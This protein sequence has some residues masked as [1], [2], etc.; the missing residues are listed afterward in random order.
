MPEAR[1]DVSVRTRWQVNLIGSF[2]VVDLSDGRDCTPSSRKACGLLAYLVGRGSCAVPRERL[3]GLLW[4]RSGEEQARASLRQALH[5]IRVATS[6]E[7]P[8]VEGDRHHC[9]IVPQRVRG[10]GLH[11]AREEDAEWLPFEDLDGLSE[12]FDDWLA[13]ER[14][15]ITETV[16][17][18]TAT[19]V[20]RSL[21]HGMG[22]KLIPLIRR[23][24]RID[25]LNE[26]FVQ[27]AMLAE[28][29]AGHVGAIRKRYRE[30]ASR[31]EKELGVAPTMGMTELEEE[32]IERL[33]HPPAPASERGAEG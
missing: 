28:F 3:A 33:T 23:L 19:W 8:P 22:A 9:W 15:R 26:D 10:G 2:R 30:Y 24:Q 5:D 14:S 16:V 11:H 32:L 18:E 17:E 13:M 7:E 12:P 27:F 4:D 31:A 25:P 20:R 21:Q 6:R 29:Q 1:S